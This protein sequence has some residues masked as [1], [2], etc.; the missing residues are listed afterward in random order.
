MSGWA[1]GP[2]GGMLAGLIAE[3]FMRAEQRDR[4]HGERALSCTTRRPRERG[5]E[6][7][8]TE[9]FFSFVEVADISCDH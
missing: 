7:M 8:S 3:A 9:P 2:G 5:E 4:L 6:R 1:E